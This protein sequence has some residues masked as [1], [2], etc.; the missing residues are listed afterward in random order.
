MDSH[1]DKEKVISEFNARALSHNNENAVLD[2]NT[3]PTTV[4]QNI[5]RNYFTKQSLKKYLRF[6]HSDVVLDFGCGVGRLTSY[7][8]PFVKEI[9]GIDKSTEMIGVANNINHQNKNIVYDLLTNYPMQYGNKRFSKIFT[10]WVLQHTGNDELTII[11]KEF[12]RILEDNGEVFLFE[13]IRSDASIIIDSIHH[14]R[15]K[16]EYIDLMKNAGFQLVKSNRVFRYPSYALSIWTRFKWL[17]N[18]SLPILSIIEFATVNRKP[19]HITY[20]TDVMIFKK[21][22]HLE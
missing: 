7:A 18:L 13:Q 9:V 11:F 16:Q 10:Y 19:A 8:A 20:S 22:N 6:N 4:H 3:S 5:F 17:P 14:Q 15:I 12:N 2:A 1:I 21:S